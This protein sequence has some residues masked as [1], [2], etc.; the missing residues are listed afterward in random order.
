MDF[1]ISGKKMPSALVFGPMYRHS[2]LAFRLLCREQGA[3]LCYS[4]MVNS[5]ALIRNNAAAR[6]LTKTCP[7]D[8]PL[9][10]QLF[11]ARLESMKK[12]AALVLEKKGFDFLDLNLGCPS[13]NVLN[14]GAGSALLKRPSRVSE[15]I[16]A[17]ADL[18][19]LPTAK[20]RVSQNALHSIKLARQ[21]EKAGACCIA[22]HARPVT[23]RNKGLVDFVALK[24]IK[25]AVG[26]PV[27]GNG[28]IDSK[29]AFERMLSKT[30]CD[31]AMVSQ[32]AI[33]NPGIFAE[34]LGKKPIPREKAFFRYLELCKKHDINCF[35]RIKQQAVS[36]FAGHKSLVPKLEQ[37]KSLEELASIALAE[38]GY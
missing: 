29:K 11:G 32:A 26:I 22:V 13:D 27:I 16:S 34:I 8:R 33:G 36:F 18:G 28:G 6:R 23:Q 21:I 30:G 3:G 19:A 10:M 35:G 2:D 20:I 24:R 14:Q 12:A 31:A 7:E 17:W 5:E 15:I 38:K 1:A 25:K 37:S 4:E 9:S